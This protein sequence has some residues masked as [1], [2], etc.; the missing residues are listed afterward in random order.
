MQEITYKSTRYPNTDRNNPKTERKFKQNTESNSPESLFRNRDSTSHEHPLSSSSSEVNF[1][2]SSIKQQLVSLKTLPKSQYKSRLSSL[3]SN[4]SPS[5]SPVSSFSLSPRNKDSLNS[6]VEQVQHSNRNVLLKPLYTLS[7]T[8]SKAGYKIHN[9]LVNGHH[10]AVLIKAGFQ[11]IKGKYV[12]CLADSH[13]SDSRN[14]LDFLKKNLLGLLEQHLHIEPELG[15]KSLASL[16][17][18]LMTTIKDS[19]INL[20]FS[21]CSLINLV[22]CGDTYFVWNIGDCQAVLAKEIDSWKCKILN[23]PHNLKNQQERTRILE[24]GGK[25]Q[26]ISSNQLK[27][28]KFDLGGSKSPRFHLTRSI[29]DISGKPI[30][31]SNRAEIS[32]FTIRPEDRFIIIANSS[33]WDLVSPGEAVA[34]VQE[35]WTGKKT[36]VCC[37]SLTKFAESRLQD[38]RA[39]DE[40]LAVMVLFFNH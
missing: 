15:A 2:K 31:I 34:L 18:F 13:G 1:P 22:V 27:S 17:E 8:V 4:I 40:D 10:T 19:E 33:F 29:G 5:N 23:K 36:E 3:L 21:G 39:A 20:N 32:K 37:E 25:I 9:G 24:F 6:N 7:N 28:E 11:N 30:G 12:F 14:I 38:H 16:D 35:G 26:E